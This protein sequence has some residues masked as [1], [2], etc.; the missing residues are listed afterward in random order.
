[1]RFYVDSPAQLLL[2]QVA[3]DQEFGLR[4]AS[5][6]PTPREQ[7][8]VHPWFGVVPASVVLGPAHGCFDMPGRHW[9]LLEGG[10]GTAALQI[11]EVPAIEAKLG[12]TLRGV[13]VP[14]AS[15][16]VQVS[17]PR[18]HALLPVG[19]RDKLDDAWID[20]QLDAGDTP[21]A[22]SAILSE[23]QGRGTAALARKDARKA[24]RGR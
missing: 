15:S 7:L 10:D 3:L 21:A 22:R 18:D 17:R 11:T 19:V 16:L 1:M 12:R 5:G 9:P 8:V 2:V 4:D 24:L 6:N 13:A 14:P 23:L 20:Q